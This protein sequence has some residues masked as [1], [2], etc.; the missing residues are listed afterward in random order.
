MAGSVG[1]RAWCS[2]SILCGLAVLYVLEDTSVCCL[3]AGARHCLL[4]ITSQIRSTGDASNARR[5]M[6]LVF[7]H[8][9]FALRIRRRQC[10]PKLSSFISNIFEASMC[11]WTPFVLS[12]YLTV[13]TFPPS[14]TEI[15]TVSLRKPTSPSSP[16]PQSSTRPRQSPR[17]AQQ[18]PAPPTPNSQT[19]Q[20]PSRRSYDSRGSND[21]R[22]QSRW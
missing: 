19:L 17:S 22:I 18:P 20:Y 14:L 12:Y 4:A 13:T 9:V 8:G 7:H 1:N 15:P 16:V 2:S 5:G 10:H 21:R 3:C 11:G 6:K